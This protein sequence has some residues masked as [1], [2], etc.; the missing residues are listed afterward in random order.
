MMEKRRSRLVP[1]APKERPRMVLTERD[2][3]VIKA[4]NDYRLLKASHIQALFFG[5]KSTAQ[6]R[7]FRL[8]QHGFLQRQF[9]PVVTGSVV[10]T[11]PLYTLGARGA[12]L[13]VEEFGY[14]PQQLR[15]PKKD[16]SWTFVEHLLHINE[17]RLAIELA[18]RTH[19]WTIEVWE[20][21]RTFRA[22]TDYVSVRGADGSRRDKPVLPDGYFRLATPRGR[23]HF[24][25]EVDR[26]REAESAF[27]PQIQVYEAYTASGQ[28]QARYSQKSLR[29][30]VVTT[31]D[32]RLRNLMQVTAKSGGDGKYWFTTFSQVSAN[33]VLTAP[34][35][36]R[37]SEVMLYPLVPA[38]K[39]RPLKRR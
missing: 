8:F 7:L 20:D 15:V 11:S 25:L 29:I 31:T 5:S 38:E 4:V 10:T 27:K 16:F 36:K 2:K 32:R 30:I 12:Q 6:Y 39:S 24:F 26:G 17:F 22:E 28:Y 1:A 21:E 9:A 13:L 35:W 18:A 3:Q 34:I 33:T 23:A 37:L 19:E 14:T